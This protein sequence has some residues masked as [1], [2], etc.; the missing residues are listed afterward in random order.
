MIVLFDAMRQPALPNE[1]EL[2]AILLESGLNP[3]PSR[4]A[5]ETASTPASAS[6]PMSQR[7]D[8]ARSTEERWKRVK[9]C[10]MVGWAGV[11]Q[12][13]LRAHVRELSS[14]PL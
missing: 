8:K 4:V 7:R 9:K 5:Y 14:S 13:F 2:K 12:S 3:I 1:Q 10:A 11:P 6:E